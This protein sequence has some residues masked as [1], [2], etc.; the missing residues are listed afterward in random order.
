MKTNICPMNPYERCLAT[1]EGRP[2]DRVPAYTPS[3]A[4]DVAS[5]IL[6]REAHTGSPTLWYAAAK[7]WMAGKNAYA[8]FQQ[9]HEEDVLA[10]NRVLDIEVVRYPWLVNIRPTQ[11]LDEYT[12]LSGD[13]DGVYKIWHWNPEVMNFHETKDTAPKRQ[14]EDWPEMAKRRLKSIEASAESAR[15]GAAVREANLQERLGNE[16]MV[17]A[18]GGSLSLGI[19]EASLM[20]CVME[21]GA[22]GDMLDCQLEVDL[23]QM[24]GIASRGI[25]VVLG[26]GDMADKNGPLYSP[27]TFRDLIF[28]RLKKLSARCNEL[29]LHYVWRTDGNIW[30]V[31]DMIFAEAGVPGYGEVDWDAAME[32]GK[33]R[34][35]FP[36]VVVWANASGHIMRIGSRDEVYNHCME[37]LK[38]SG[39]RRYFHGVSNT[40]LPGTPPENVWA[41]MEARDDF[42]VTDTAS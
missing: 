22:A 39:G 2:I 42:A 41:M 33:I 37:I 8:E 36:D 17:V 11:Q 14:P 29:G 4:C 20:A 16:M 1:I 28:P 10:L 9:K 24:E 5:K 31:S 12:F 6:G 19:D 35:R 32:T 15:K 40:I 18:G 26:G 25:K 30:S 34:E 27:Q 3:I 21:P 38:E 23:A 7:A 13:P